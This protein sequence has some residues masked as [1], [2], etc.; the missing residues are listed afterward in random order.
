MGRVTGAEYNRRRPL[1]AELKKV[2]PEVE[3][4]TGYVNT[5][6]LVFRMISMKRFR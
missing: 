4:A 2:I 3:H 1:P 6:G 5:S